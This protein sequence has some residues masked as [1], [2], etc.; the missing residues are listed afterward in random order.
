MYAALYYP[1]S[2]IRDE[3][4]LKTSLLLWD[5]LDVIVPS[6]GFRLSGGTRDGDEALEL[7]GVA[8]TP[9]DEEKL[10]AHKRVMALANSAPSECL[11]FDLSN[12]NLRYEVYADK[13]LSDTWRA[14]KDSQLA[15]EFQSGDFTDYALSQWLGLT[16]M[17]VLAEECAGTEKRL[18]T[19]EQDSYAALGRA[20]TAQHGGSYSSQAEVDRERL[21]TL[22]IRMINSDG[23]TLRRLIHLRKSEDAFLRS[24]RHNYLEALDECVSELSKKPRA[25]DR[26]EIERRFEER[27]KDDL[28]ELRKALVGEAV[29]SVFS[30]EMLVA[31]MAAAGAVVEPWTSSVVGVGAL[32]KTWRDY[33]SKRADAMRKHPMAWLLQTKRI[34]FV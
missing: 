29:G 9:S 31:V 30:K 34:Q 22:N 15:S 3:A 21:L 19:D 24:L 1:H 13:F 28:A 32:G 17:S 4:L 16:M 20:F 10:A 6:K 8:R 12:P 23:V 27:M 11:A 7:I 5:Q 14:L 26:Q 18:L 25:S 2:S 33:R